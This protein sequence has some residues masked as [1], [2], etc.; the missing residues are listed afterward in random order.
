MS[1]SRKELRRFIT[2]NILKGLLWFGLI[3]LAFV[4]LRNLFDDYEKVLEGLQG[5]PFMIYSV[6][7]VSEM[8]FGIIP[9]EIIV[10]IYKGQGLS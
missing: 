7:F 6:F 10:E 5:R 9:P 8:S 3:V 2:S 4:A 1:D